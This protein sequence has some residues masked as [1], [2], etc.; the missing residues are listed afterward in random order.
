MPA[1]SFTA[2]ELACPGIGADDTDGLTA[3]VNQYDSAFYASST[4]A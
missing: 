2:G 1:T 3:L 4:T